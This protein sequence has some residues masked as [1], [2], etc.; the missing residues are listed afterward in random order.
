MCGDVLIA[1][2][3]VEV[4]GKACADYSKEPWKAPVGSVVKAGVILASGREYLAA[5]SPQ[6][7][8]VSYMMFRRRFE[9]QGFFSVDDLGTVIVGG[10]PEHDI[11]AVDQKHPVS[12]EAPFVRIS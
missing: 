6:A 4:T 2:P 7:L 5:P 1:E 3:A 12:D 10:A 9:A 8:E 11:W